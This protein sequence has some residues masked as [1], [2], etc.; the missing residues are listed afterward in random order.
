MLS[1]LSLLALL[2]GCKSDGSL[3]VSLELPTEADL[4]P[5]GDARLHRVSLV[6]TDAA[7]EVKKISTV[8][9][10]PVG[11][12]LDIGEVPVGQAGSLTLIGY[13]S[14]NQVLSYGEASLLN[15]GA[16]DAVI[17]SMAFRKP[18]AYISGG[19]EISI[20]DTSRSHSEDLVQ[21]IALDTENQLTTAVAT[22][23]DGRH[24]LAAVA[25]S[26]A[27]PPPVP[28]ASQLIIFNTAEHTQSFAV[29]LSHRPD[30]LSMSPEGRWAVLSST[31]ENWVTVVDVAA[32]IGGASPTTV[33]HE[34]VFAAPKRAAFVKTANGDD[35]AVI[36]RDQAPINIDEA[37]TPAPQPST[38]S[39]IELPS[40]NLLNSTALTSVA[41]DIASRPGDSRVF[42]AQPC[43]G[44]IAVFD[45][46]TYQESNLITA[47]VPTS[48]IVKDDTLWIGSADLSPDGG[49]TAARIAISAVDLNTLQRTDPV[50]TPFLP[51]EFL[52]REDDSAASALVL[53]ANPQAV[54]VYHLSVP[55]GSTRISALIYA[56]YYGDYRSSPIPTTTPGLEV[57]EMEIFSFSYVGLDTTTGELRRRYRSEC[58]IWFN[59]VDT[60]YYC[61]TALPSHEAPG[62]LDGYVPTG[63]TSLFGAP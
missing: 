35:L 1:A 26:L 44:R 13:S 10:N 51:E 2:G 34:I 39:V 7:G 37:C 32:V 25:D 49:A 9:W 40:G 50:A 58:F 31:A 46:L 38:L 6:V 8:P 14:T 53:R 52:L 3:T 27:T 12:Q 36:L 42:V 5:I 48:L 11:R 57:G 28:Q 17:V 24:V 55:P 63:A 33:T 20:F 16:R 30:Y 18:F 45:S 4:N 15:I 61:C 21:P 19:P 60:D 29:P 22:T 47:Q 41:R 59:R 56:T 62:C 54:R 43:L 23:P